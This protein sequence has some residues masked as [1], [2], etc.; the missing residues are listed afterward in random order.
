DRPECQ[1]VGTLLKNL[2]NVRKSELTGR[3]FRFIEDE[4]NG[5]SLESVGERMGD[6]VGV[7]EFEIGCSGARRKL[8]HCHLS[9]IARRCAWEETD[10][11]AKIDAFFNLMDEVGASD[12]HLATGSQPIL[13]VRGEMER[14]KFDVLENDEL[15]SML[16]EI[17]PEF[18]IKLF[19]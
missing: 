4:S 3:T 2:L 16:Y 13:R 18:K 14:V 19:E 6:A 10:E 15:K 12:L 9:I 5:P 11:M 8:T 17:A 7:L 1:S